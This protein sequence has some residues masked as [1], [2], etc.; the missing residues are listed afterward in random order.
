MLRVVAA[1]TLAVMVTAPPLLACASFTFA[2]SLTTSATGTTLHVTLKNNLLTAQR[3]T[4]K[5][6]L[7][8][9]TATGTE[10]YP[11]VSVVVVL[12]PRFDATLSVPL[13]IPPGTPAGTYTLKVT[14]TN[15]N[16]CSESQTLTLTVA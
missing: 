6:D 4:I 1:L 14:V 15:A 7:S 5:Y 2:A 3:L 12:P 13:I 16:G 11:P 9:T 8:V 10:T